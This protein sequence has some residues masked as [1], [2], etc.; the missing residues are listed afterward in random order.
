MPIFSSVA[1]ATSCS[2]LLL[3]PTTMPNIARLCREIAQRL[4]H[5]NRKVV[6]GESCTAGLVSAMLARV[7]GISNHLCG[8]AVTYRSETKAAWLKI[9]KRLLESPGPVSDRVAREMAQQ[10]LRRTPEA[11]LAISITGHLGPN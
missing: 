2:I 11:D 1:S 10:V 8:S 6:F 4:Q 7:P 5:L 9:S 3:L